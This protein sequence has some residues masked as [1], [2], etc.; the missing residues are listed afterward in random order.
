MP[1]TFLT[2]DDA[3]DEPV[4]EPEPY[5]IRPAGE[6]WR[7]P[8]SLG[9][10][11]VAGA[12]LL[13]VLA[14]YLLF[15]AVIVDAAG[16]GSAAGVMVGA[17]VVVIAFT[18][19]LLRVGVWVSAEGLRVVALSRTKTL[20]WDQVRAV[21]TAQQPVR[22]LGLPR[23]VQGQALLLRRADGTESPMLTDH[24]PD[25]LGRPEAFD[26]TADDIEAWATAPHRS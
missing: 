23:V 4:T 5:R 19:R 18:L 2:A 21:R 26:V 1:L 25:F 20:A 22:W 6:R 11:R 15:A 16:N 14:A 12:A 24:N 17:G 7:R 3:H 8:Y 9:P 13:L 10:W